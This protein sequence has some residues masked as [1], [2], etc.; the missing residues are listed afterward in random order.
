MF[1]QNVLCLPQDRF[2]ICSRSHNKVNAQ[3]GV[4]DRNGP[5]VKVV[6]VNHTWNSAQGLGDFHRVH[7]RRNAFHQNSQRCRENFI[8]GVKYQDRE[9]KRGRRVRELHHSIVRVGRRV[10]PDQRSSNTHANTLNQIAN[11]VHVR[12]RHVDVTGGLCFRAG[13]LP[14][15]SKKRRSASTR[16]VGMLVGVTVAMAMT[17][18]LRFMG[19]SCY[20]CA[21][22]VAMAMTT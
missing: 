20:S 16:S 13:G 1:P 15:G 6:H 21:V 18:V 11:C 4:A 10:S 2:Q 3:G 17:V 19:C 14:A 22:A 12:C 9:Q 7:V 5:D 8:R